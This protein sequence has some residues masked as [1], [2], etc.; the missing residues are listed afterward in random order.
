MSAV[1]VAAACD[2]ITKVRV[3]GFRHVSVQF[4]LLGI[5]IVGWNRT[6]SHRDLLVREEF[7]NR[8]PTAKRYSNA[9]STT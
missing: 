7:D 8:V 6:K 5:Q 2:Q 1:T 4:T 9:A 3:N